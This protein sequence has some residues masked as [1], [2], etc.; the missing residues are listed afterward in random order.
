MVGRESF[1]FGFGRNDTPDI[2]LS[3]DGALGTVWTEKSMLRS[4]GWCWGSLP[5]LNVETVE[6]AYVAENRRYVF[7]EPGTNVS[8]IR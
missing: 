1:G 4:H 3:S 5:V 2:W 8:V 6:W 7:W